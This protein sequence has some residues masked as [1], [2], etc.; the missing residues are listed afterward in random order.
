MSYFLR[1]TRSLLLVALAMLAAATAASADPGTV[2]GPRGLS[3]TV[4]DTTPAPGQT[5]TLDWS[6]TVPNPDPDASATRALMGFGD[7]LGGGPAAVNVDDLSFDACSGQFTDCTYDT[8]FA[9]DFQAGVPIGSPDD[10]I[11]GSA[12]FTVSPSATT[13]ETISFTGY[14]LAGF[15]PPQAA[16]TVYTSDPLELTVTA[17]PSA[18]LGVSLSASSSVLL[19]DQVNY[20]VAVTNNGPATAS[21]A[22]ITTQLPSEATSIASTT[23]TY[24]S[25]TDRVTCPIGSLANGA[26][27][28]ATFTAFYGLLT[29]GLPLH[30]QA[31]RTAGSPT[32]PNA[33][34]DSD[35]ADC[36][37]L[38]A[39][40]IAC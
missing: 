37:A 19:T 33:A 2:T 1:S 18:D 12:T 36:T 30:A 17:P 38:T 27:T 7:R 13:G 15:A 23:C 11:T 26:T 22:T 29:V 21:S 31:T 10:T 39:L 24:S 8:A 28:H 40:I 3:M 25:S 32:D 14:H 34:N 9:L 16:D 4:D 35:G 5:I 20:D 6:Y